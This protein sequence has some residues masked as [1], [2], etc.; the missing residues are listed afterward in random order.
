M[1]LFLIVCF[2]SRSR[3]LLRGRMLSFGSRIHSRE[4][5]GV[6]LRV[7]WLLI[8]MF[9]RELDSGEVVRSALFCWCV[10][11]FSFP[12]GQQ[13]GKNKRSMKAKHIQAP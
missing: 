9:L 10:L 1:C 2:V 12:N 5:R 8:W 6:G 13:S 7:A 4:C 3:M 11:L